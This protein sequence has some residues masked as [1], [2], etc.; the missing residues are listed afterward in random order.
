MLYFF[1]CD[2]RFLLFTEVKSLFHDVESK[3]LE[4]IPLD[5]RKNLVLENRKVWYPAEKKEMKVEFRACSTERLFLLDLIKDLDAIIYIDTDILF[6]EPPEKL[7]REFDYFDEN[8]VLGMSPAFKSDEGLKK[9]TVNLV[10][11]I[12]SLFFSEN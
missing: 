1:L 11:L 2:F 5:Y 6:L 3:L 12:G 10:K 4:E 7:W 9:E 8:Q